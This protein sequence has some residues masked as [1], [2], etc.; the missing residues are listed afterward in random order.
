MPHHGGGDLGTIAHLHLVASWSHA[1]YIELLHDP[2]TGDYRHRFSIMRDPPLLDKDGFI[3][4]PQGH[5][6]GVEINP[7]LMEV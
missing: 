7:D 4:V 2:P 1:P 6:L 3:H 5:G